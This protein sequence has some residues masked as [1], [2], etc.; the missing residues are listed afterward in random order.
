M[1][2]AQVI[3]DVAAYPVDRPF[4]YLVPEDWHNLIEPGCRVKV[5][6]G[7]RNVLGFVVGLASETEVP[8][9]KIKPIAQI[10]DIEPV[11]TGEMLQLAKWLKHETICYEIDA[12]QVMLPSALRA[13]YDKIIHLQVASDELEPQLRPYFG[14]SGKANFKEFEKNQLLREIK[15]AASLGQVIIENS[16]KQQGVVKH[17]RKVE[18]V[19]DMDKLQAIHAN[20]SNRAQKQK[21]LVEWMMGHLGETLT[22]DDMSTRW[23]DICCTTCRNRARRGRFCARGSVPRSLYERCHKDGFLTAN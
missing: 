23:G 10:L 8:L 15:H 19:A 3:V 20:I 7:P 4:D 13:K 18:I 9:E 1:K 17:V 11:L 2:V 6:F 5:P 14:K 16:V 22:P 21:Q 12:L